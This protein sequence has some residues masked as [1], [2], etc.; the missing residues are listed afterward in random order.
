MRCKKCTQTGVKQHF[1]DC[2]G[3]GVDFSTFYTLY[4]H[5]ACEFI[6]MSWKQTHQQ[7]KE[8][9]HSVGQ[10]IN[11]AGVFDCSVFVF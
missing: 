5:V 2:R 7:E 8:G 11:S 3:L 4:H 10:G 6:S 1:D 9:H